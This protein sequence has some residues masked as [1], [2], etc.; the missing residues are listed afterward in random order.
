[1]SKSIMN[2]LLTEYKMRKLYNVEL[3]RTYM[4][5]IEAES[6]EDAKELT[7]FF[8]GTSKDASNENN[9]T[10]FNFDIKNIDLRDNESNQVYELKNERI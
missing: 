6:K 4:V 9:K 2:S 7:E 3:I 8:V 1:M 5:T 10:D